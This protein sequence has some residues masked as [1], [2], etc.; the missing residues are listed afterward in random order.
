MRLRQTIPP[1]CLA[2]RIFD[3]GISIVCYPSHVEPN[4][5][6]IISNTYSPILNPTSDEVVTNR[7]QLEQQTIVG[8]DNYF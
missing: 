1:R 5:Q 3:E 2:Y 4:I 6:A 7:F 8:E